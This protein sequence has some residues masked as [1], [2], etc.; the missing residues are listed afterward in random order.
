MKPIK[1][2]IT[3]LLP[4]GPAGGVAQQA[5][6]LRANFDPSAGLVPFPN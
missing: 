6:T 1:T 5:A 4:D 2:L 3:V